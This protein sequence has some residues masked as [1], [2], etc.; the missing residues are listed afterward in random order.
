MSTPDRVEVV[1]RIPDEDHQEAFYQLRKT[2]GHQ[3][4]STNSLIIKGY[5]YIS[6]TFVIAIDTEKVIEAGSAGSTHVPEIS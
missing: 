6:I 4:S 3:P 5:E 1:P 2:L